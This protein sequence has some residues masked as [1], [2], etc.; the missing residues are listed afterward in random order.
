MFTPTCCIRLVT[1]TILA[2]HQ[3]DV[4]WLSLPDVRLVT[5]TLLAMS[6]TDTPGGVTRWL[7]HG[8]YYWLVINGVLTAQNNLTSERCE[9]WYPTNPYQ[10]LLSFMHAI[11]GQLSM[12]SHH[13]ATC[14]KP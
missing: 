6:S 11:S 14:S 2:C 3:L 10:R 4:L 5:W 12:V 13:S 7:L 8:P 9:K 1:W